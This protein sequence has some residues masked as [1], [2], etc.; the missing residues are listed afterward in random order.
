[1]KKDG[2]DEYIC[3]GCGLSFVHPQPEAEW[4]KEKVYSYESGYQ[5]NKKIDLS[6]TFCDERTGK[7]LDFLV[8]QK[9]GGTLLDIG[10]SSGQLMYHARKRGFSCSGVEINKRTADMAAANGFTVHQGFLE[11]CPFK[12]KS[13]DVIYL[14]DVIEHINNPRQFVQTCR[15]FLKDDGTIAI[16]TPNVDCWWSRVTLLLYKF[17]CIPWSS[18]TPPHHLF[19]FGTMSLNKLLAEQGYKCIKSIHTGPTSLRYELG[20]L[21]L[22]GAW[23]RKKTVK[24]LSFMLFSYSLYT[25]IFALTRILRPFIKKRFHMVAIYAK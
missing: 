23:K 21:H 11:T 17:F 12:K 16:S 10:C 20:S 14:G 3:P 19:Q 4:L 1:M 13:F 9:R 15:S 22:F 8:E 6:L 25:L 18:A 2:F 24:N 5:G 7:A